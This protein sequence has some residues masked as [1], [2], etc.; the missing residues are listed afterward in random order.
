MRKILKH[1]TAMVCLC[2]LPA[3][4]NA[5]SDSL[6]E[7]SPEASP[8]GTIKTIV[9]DPGHGGEDTGAVGPTGVME[10]D[11]TLSVAKALKKELTEKTGTRVFLTRTYDTYMSLED[12]AALANEVKAGVFISIHVNA[13]PRKGA[14]GVETFFLSF[15][16]SDD[17]AREVAAFENNVIRFDGRVAGEPTEDLKAI[18]WDLTQTE[19]HHE[20]AE[21]A[22]SIQHALSGVTNG[23]DRGV[24]QAPFIVLFGATMPSVL[25]EIGFISNPTEEKRLSSEKVQND[26]AGAISDGVVAFERLLSKRVGLVE[27]KE[28]NEKN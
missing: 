20:S 22:E 23:D 13:A 18:L 25:V 11:I 12:R 19:A 6:Q 14:T 16:A 15:D 5:F 2:L 24:K 7:S 4:A 26:I 27:L 17:E 8:E 1:L 3:Q 9:I 10:K 21:L 28:A